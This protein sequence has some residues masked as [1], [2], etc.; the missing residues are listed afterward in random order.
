MTP[1]PNAV[2]S[3]SIPEVYERELGPLLFIPYAEDLG[4]RVAALDPTTVLE[5]ACG[6][7]ISTRALLRHLP[8][9]ARLVATDLQQAMIDVARR[10][11]ADDPRVEW[12]TAD[13]VA[14]PFDD[15]RFDVV[16]T[17][18]GMM[19]PPD[20]PAAFAEAHRVI[21][22][23]GAFV[24]NVWDS[25]DANP[26]AAVAERVIVELFPKDPPRFYHTPW[27]FHDRGELAAITK[28]AG[29]RDPSIDVVR[30]DVERPNARTAARALVEG[31][32]IY[33]QIVERGTVPVDRIVD[34]MERAFACEFGDAPLRTHIQALV[35]TATA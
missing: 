32:P 9:R 22:A 33:T 4:A 3:G 28:G 6:T 14:L 25:F 8:A 31:T 35:I 7:G 19:F 34:T 30:F 29:F 13:M 27:G 20:R 17:Q 16:A 15:G 21:R 12:R 18:F 24:F 26:V 10:E 5:T 11:S 2:F 1:E 23:G